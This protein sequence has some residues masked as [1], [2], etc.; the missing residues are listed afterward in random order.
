[1]ATAVSLIDSRS[2]FDLS[3]LS[4]ILRKVEHSIYI[5]GF[6]PSSGSSLVDLSLTQ[7]ARCY[8]VVAR[9]EPQLDVTPLLPAAGW[10]ISRP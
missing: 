7:L 4:Q 9:H 3:I 8:D 10:T 1:M 5:L 6:K 2:T